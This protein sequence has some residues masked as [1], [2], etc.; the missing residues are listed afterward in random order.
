MRE[1]TW[2]PDLNDPGLLLERSK[3]FFYSDEILA[4]QEQRVIA[5]LLTFAAVLGAGLVIIGL[6]L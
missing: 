2:L 5:V 3:T 6:V 4:A 1:D